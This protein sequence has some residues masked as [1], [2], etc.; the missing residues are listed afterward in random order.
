MAKSPRPR[1]SKRP[2]RPRAGRTAKNHQAGLEQRSVS[3]EEVMASSEL[4]LRTLV[5]LAIGEWSEIA[6]LEWPPPSIRRWLEKADVRQVRGILLT[7][8]HRWHELRRRDA[9]RT[10]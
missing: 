6:D 8:L 5:L 3:I 9:P 4:D 1:K 10:P 2:G 7:T